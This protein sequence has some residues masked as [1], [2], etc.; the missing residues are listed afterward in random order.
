TP[1]LAGWVAPGNSEPISP[2]YAM[3]GLDNSS[4]FVDPGADRLTQGFYAL[5]DAV[6]TTN[7]ANGRGVS[8]ALAHVYELVDLLAAHPTV[9]RGQAARFAGATQALLAPWLHEAI[10]NDRGRAGLWEAVAA[11][12]PPQLPPPGVVHFGA[13]V[14]ASTKDAEVWRRVAHVMMSLVSPAELYGNAE[15]AER[16]G[17]ALAGGPPPQLPGASRAELVAA[18]AAAGASAEAA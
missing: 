18:I 6:C 7:P 17:A 2:V 3:G 9:D 4:R 1:M 14:A 11:G 13:A 16:I 5:G 15:M 8:L 12:R 10:A